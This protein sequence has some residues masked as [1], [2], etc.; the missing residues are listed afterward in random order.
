MTIAA[1][2]AAAIWAAWALI[3]LLGLE[4]GFPLVQL[5][6]FTPFAAATSPIPIAFALL[7]RRR[8]AAVLAAAAAVVLVALV[9]PRAVGGP[10][11]AAGEPGPSLRVLAANMKLGEGNPA[12]L[13]ELTETLDVDVLSVEELTPELAVALARKGLG[14]LLPYRRLASDRGSYGVGLYSRVRLIESSTV[15]LPGGFPLVRA[16]LRLPEGPELEVA[17]VHTQPPT[18]LGSAQWD[19]DLRSLP[20]AAE[21]PVRIL[22]GDFN[23]TVDHDEFRALVDRGYA[24]VAETLGDGLTPTW[25][26]HRSFPPLVTIDHVLVDERVGIRDYSTHEIAHSD[27]RAVYA[28]LQLPVAP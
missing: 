25:P 4:A 21:S 23:A 27:H 9:V 19:D 28:E 2:L 17:S 15:E 3:R 18:R 13:V 26:E 14:D 12:R 10:T 24:D 11:E 20:S 6:A 8:A 5:V 1:W 7:L 22:L 16:H